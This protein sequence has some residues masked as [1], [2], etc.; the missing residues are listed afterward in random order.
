MVA[1][2]RSIL[3]AAM[4][5]CLLAVPSSAVPSPAAAASES[6]LMAAEIN[7]KRSQYG[8]PPLRA[9]S[10]LNR[11]SARYARHIMRSSRFSHA[12][13]IRASRSFSGLG[14]VL[15]LRRGWRARIRRTVGLWMRSPGHR[16]VLLS[17]RYRWLGSGRVRG[18]FGGTRTTAWVVQV[19]R[20]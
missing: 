15:S 13:R 9:S 17:T 3:L 6:R 8:L 4:L 10:S 11:S 16:S 12:A 19:G 20:R 14:E 5:A 2:V 18:R 1:L 7:L